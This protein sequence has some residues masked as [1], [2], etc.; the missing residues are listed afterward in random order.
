MRAV[1]PLAVLSACA[2]PAPVRTGESP[3]P[4][5]VVHELP[6]G[7]TVRL[8]GPAAQPAGAL[9]DPQVTSLLWREALRQ[10]ARFDFAGGVEDVAAPASLA[11]FCDVAASRWSSSLLRD[12]EAPLPLASVEA[13]VVPPHQAIDAL[14][15]R[16]R[17]ALGD[18]PEAPPRSCARIVSQD[19]RVSLL[20]E[21]A[22]TGHGEGERSRQLE[23]AR[24]AR[25]LDAA[26]TP[27]L[28]LLAEATLETGDAEQ[29]R[30]VALE[31]LG[32]DDRLA[33]S[34][35]H[36]LARVLIL[37]RTADLRLR[38][39][40]DRELQALAAAGARERPHDPHVQFT[41]ALAASLGGDFAAAAPLWRRLAERWPRSG[42]AAYHLAFAELANGDAAAALAATERARALLPEHRILVPR[43]LALHALRRHDE[44][45]AYLAGVVAE[46]AVQQGS[47]LHDLRRI[48]AAHALLVGDRER[49][50][51]HLLEDLEW[52]RQRS[53][54]LEPLAIDVVEAGEVLVR[55]GKQAEL[56][57]RLIALDQ[58]DPPPAARQAIDYLH[59]LVTVARGGDPA[60]VATGLMR[61]G[62]DAA[63]QTTV[64]GTLLQAAWH[65]ERG[66]LLDEAT[67][68][69][70][71]ALQTENPLVH[72]SLARAMR[73]AG[74]DG[75]A[76]AVV[77]SV[78]ARLTK[79]DLRDLR[80][81][82]LL[83]PASALATLALGG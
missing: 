33:P 49:A 23:I 76:T 25:P 43:L 1:L 53:S 59:G 68:L 79:I 48:Q 60:P 28:L 42:T 8:L 52:I 24:R 17:I 11:L 58:A 5:A 19:P 75:P 70:R 27:V 12:G 62:A 15:L 10:S 40:Q 45:D 9:R 83:N 35:T 13:P 81:H 38:R 37:A 7:T 66:E 54:L 6:E 47:A 55:L 50:A 34:T 4:A 14:A 36:R 61:E 51:R 63:V 56:A 69:G 18:R 77:E 78:R 64:W 32:Y 71:A 73:S 3:A 67:L 74:K 16:T 57:P 41:R 20:L 46:P 21:E 65:R 80:Q 31:A 44:L 2:G 82:P 26:C 72:A 39:E 29:A 22:S 30:R